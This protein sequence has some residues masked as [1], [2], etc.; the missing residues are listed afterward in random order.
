M[1]AVAAIAAGVGVASTVAGGIVQ[2]GAAKKAARG[3]KNAKDAAAA[4]VADLKRRR[5]PVINPYSGVQSL[6]DMAQDLSNQMKNPY[7]NL[8]VATQAAEMQAEESDIALASTLDTMRATGA[9]AGGATALAQAALK[10][11]KG[12]AANIESQEAANEKLRAQGEQQL[13]EAK[14]AEQQ[15]LQGIA[16]SEGQR[17][18]AALAQGKIFQFQAKEDRQNADIEYEISKEMG[19][20][21]REAQA[22]Q[23]RSDAIGGIFAGVGNIAG[24]VVGAAGANPDL[25]KSGKTSDRRMKKNIKLIG[26]SNSG[27]NIYAFEYIN[28]MFGEGVWQ[29]VMSDEVSSEAV[30][31][32][33]A[34]DF[35]GVDY[36]KVD[37]EFKR[38]S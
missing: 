12:I 30:I 16:I 1:A 33:F 29:G 8:G 23:A 38:I 34:G 26:K 31:K 17:E 9:G 20:A 24:S 2:A 6:A 36:S 28:K 18:Q 10:S 5:Q 27:L 22:N 35:D 19:A 4:R 15:R 7:A 25:F 21:Q 32:N 37:V 3:A 13:Q 14:V 11:K